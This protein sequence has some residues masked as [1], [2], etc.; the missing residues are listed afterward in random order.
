MLREVNL[1]A[2]V[3]Q[4][5]TNLGKRVNSPDLDIVISAYLVQKDV[6]GNLT[7]IMEKVAET[8]RERIRIQGDIKVLTAQGRLSGLIVG[9][10]PFVLFLFF[11]F[12]A[13]FYFEPMFGPPLIPLFGM[14]VP[15]G[16]LMLSAALFWQLVGG[17]VIY[18]V[19]D[20]K[21]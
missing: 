16:V 4:A 7:E 13:P 9:L 8:I 15:V 10:L 20:I 3:E 6:G 21:V 5:L 1:G 11:L 12:W 17:Y 2:T 18:K 19:I 14:D